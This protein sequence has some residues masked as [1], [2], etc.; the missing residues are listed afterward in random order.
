MSRAMKP[1]L[2]ERDFDVDPAQIRRRREA[3]AKA[4]ETA[5]AEAAAIA[6]APPPPSYS[7]EELDQVAEE[8]FQRGIAQG[9][10]EAMTGIEQRQADTCQ[11]VGDRIDGLLRGQRAAFDEM[12][13]E[14]LE[15]TYT[16]LRRLSPELARRGGLTEI[17]AVIAEIFHN[18]RDEPKVIARVHP[19]MLAGIAPRLD[20]AAAR[21]GFEG[22]LVLRGDESLA[23]GD[24][25]L[26]WADGGA[27]RVSR[28]LW[29]RID[30]ALERL[31]GHTP[32]I[33]DRMPEGNEMTPATAE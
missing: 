8:S 20:E 1:F 17:E 9:R 16:L 19:D 18:L 22:Q 23:E 27:E 28:E 25:R 32:Q 11:A 6:A 33:R 2:F 5:D 13:G 24:C 10:A 30:A 7:Q 21:N 4:R 12:A 15:L 29:R 3:E 14:M 26:E 31:I